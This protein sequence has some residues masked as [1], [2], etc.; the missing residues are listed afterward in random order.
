MAPPTVSYTLSHQIAKKNMPWAW[1]T[2]WQ[3][4]LIPAFRK[5]RWAWGGY[6]VADLWEFQVSLVCIVNLRPAKYTVISCLHKEKKGEGR[7]EGD[8]QRDGEKERGEGRERDNP[9]VNLV[10]AIP[11]LRFSLPRNLLFM[12]S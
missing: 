11:Q 9:Q 8:R 1:A 3:A 12:S 4:S 5:Q 2:G 6:R 7:I 10:E